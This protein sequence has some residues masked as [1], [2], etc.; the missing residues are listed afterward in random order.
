MIWYTSLYWYSLH[1][2]L[3]YTSCQ[4]VRFKDFPHRETI[5]VWYNLSLSEGDLEDVVQWGLSESWTM[6]TSW[7]GLLIPLTLLRCFLNLDLFQELF[8]STKSVNLTV[9]YQGAHST[10]TSSFLCL[11][12]L[13]FS[14]SPGPLIGD[15]DVESS[16]V[17]S[18]LT[19]WTLQACWNFTHEVSA[20]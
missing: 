5:M 16:L 4:I 7:S 10:S 12:F 3:R 19:D 1:K 9:Y 8:I 6:A 13:S 2:T 15:F 14:S 17:E 20:F 18:L 11:R